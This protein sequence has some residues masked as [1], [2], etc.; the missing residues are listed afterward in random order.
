[1]AAQ[2]PRE[3]SLK[4]VSDLTGL[5]IDAVRRR[6]DRGSIPSAKRG[7]R[8]FVQLADLY[9]LGLVRI[10]AG[11]TVRDLLDRLERQAERIGRLTQALTAAGVSVPDA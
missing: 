5:S 2:P 10:D 11:A 7:G 6:V 3:L 1:V 8:R 9:D 4:D